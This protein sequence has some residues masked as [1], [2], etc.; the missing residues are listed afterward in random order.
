MSVTP[1]TSLVQ[2][3][4]SSTVVIAFYKG[5]IL[6]EGVQPSRTEKKQVLFP[7]ARLRELAMTLGQIA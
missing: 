7:E 6:V 1:S 4:R 2:G 3:G 5:R